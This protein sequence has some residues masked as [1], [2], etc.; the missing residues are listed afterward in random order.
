MVTAVGPRHLPLGTELSP[1]GREGQGW[2]EGS[3]APCASGLRVGRNQGYFWAEGL[4]SLS[5]ES[6]AEGE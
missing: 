6:E 5:S 2:G 1:E 3:R 4:L